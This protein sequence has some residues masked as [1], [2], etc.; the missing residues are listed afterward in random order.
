MQFKKGSI[1]NS[2]FLFQINQTSTSAKRYRVYARAENASTLQVRSVASA[3][4][5]KPG[6]LKPIPA[7]TKTSARRKEFARTA[8]A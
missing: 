7:R 5:A 8:D 1:E 4:T 6:I 3:P 2:E